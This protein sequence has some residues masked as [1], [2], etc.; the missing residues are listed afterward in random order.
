MNR[1]EFFSR[2]VAGTA[3]AV[4]GSA[5]GRPTAQAGASGR[6]PRKKDSPLKLLFADRRDIHNTK[7][8][9]RFGATPLRRLGNPP[10]TEFIVKYCRPRG[11]GAYDVW[12]FQ[13][14]DH[15][16]WKVFRCRSRDGMHFDDV[17]VVLERSGEPWAHTCSISYSPELGRFLLL[18]NR[19]VPDGFSMYAYFSSDGDHWEEYER[20]PV[21]YDG[22]RW[23][24]LWSPAIQKF[25]YYG[26]GIQRYQQKLFPEL[27][28]NA[29]RVVTLRTSPDGFHWTPDAPSFYRR[30][31]RI[32]EG[33]ADGLRQ[34][35]GP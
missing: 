24:A 11:D 34:V 29:R 7:G 19:N 30:G 3:W 4:R 2:A 35:G 1:R 26:K 6:E 8:Q 14:A 27:F 33:R 31:E 23:G 18:K 20:N 15:H 21:F 16:P 10:A 12:G 9:L 32:P 13:G 25:V 5:F 17:R 22:D 28:A